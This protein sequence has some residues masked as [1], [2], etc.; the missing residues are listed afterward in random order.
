M[1]ILAG[2]VT[3]YFN[4]IS[5]A[6]V[7]VKLELKTGDVI[8]VMGRNTEFT[9]KIGSMEIEHT[10]IYTCDPGMEIAL[11]VVEPVYK[12]DNVFKVIENTA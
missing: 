9:Q 7:H 1:E 10:K 11:K 3:H 4:R 12:G 6:V 5:V 2:K 8:H